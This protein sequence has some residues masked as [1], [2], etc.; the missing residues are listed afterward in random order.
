MVKDNLQV[1]ERYALLPAVSNP[2]DPKE[3]FSALERLA[4]KLN[5][6]MPTIQVGN[7]RY[8][9]TGFKLMK[10]DVKI[11]SPKGIHVSYDTF[12]NSLDSLIQN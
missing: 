5:R 3:V 12:L 1:N 2:Q 9:L 8:P 6:Q 10:T 4:I 11:I 7:D